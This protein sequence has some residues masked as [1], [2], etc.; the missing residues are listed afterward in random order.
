MQINLAEKLKAKRREHGVTQEKLA[1][2]LNVSFQAVSKWENSTAYPDISLLPDIARFFDIT[3]DELLQAEVI[4]DQKL[5]FQYEQKAEES[6]RNGGLE[7]ALVMWQ[8]AYKKLPNN[9]RVKECLM[10]AYFDID[11][12]KYQKEI[13]EL[14]TELYNSQAPSYYKGQ[15]VSQIAGTYA[16][17]G[18]LD[19]AKQWASKAYYLMHSREMIYMQIIKDGSELLEQFRFANYWY[20]NQLFY[21]AARIS[22]CDT[23]PGGEKL[24]QDIDKAVAEIHEIFYPG[25][26]M[27]FEELGNMTNQHRSI[28]EEETKLSANEEVVRHHLQLAS[29]CALKSVGITAHTLTHPLLYGWQV[30]AAPSDNL[31]IVRMLK[32]QMD[33]ECFNKYKDTQWFKDILISLNSAEQ[34]A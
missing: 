8:E 4:D 26:D 28:A 27:S 30:E 29:E 23:I 2:F 33:W 21:M 31:R 17:S 3:V 10:S 1:Q 34:P 16:E 7:E 11:K 32:K 20:M 5:V 22:E 9:A 18:C 14:G 13:I 24:I 12:V 25:G 19:A 6:V 15:A